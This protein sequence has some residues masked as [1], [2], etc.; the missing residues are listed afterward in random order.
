MIGQICDY[1]HNYFANDGD[2]HAGEYSIENGSI[3]LPFLLNGQYFRVIGS[4]LND[5][6]YQYPAYGLSDET[7]N[8]EIWAMRVPRDVLQIASEVAEWV[9]KYGDKA[10]SPFQSENVIGVYNY[11]K[12]MG[13]Q[14]ADYGPRSSW[15]DVFGTRLSRWRKLA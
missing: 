3:T 1:I 5:G 10:A 2:K 6:V 14:G 11:A 13:G 15:H 7:F 12:A 8:G 4:A 9:E